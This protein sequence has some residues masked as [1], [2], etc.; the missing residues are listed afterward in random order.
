[1]LSSCTTAG[2]Y[3][4][5]C[6]IRFRLCAKH[7]TWV[8]SASP[9]VPFILDAL[10]VTITESFASNLHSV[11]AS[12]SNPAMVFPVWLSCIALVVAH[13]SPASTHSLCDALLWLRT[14]QWPLMSKRRMSK[15]I[16][17][18]SAEIPAPSLYLLVQLGQ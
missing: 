7:C 10:S 5:F 17:Q 14:I 4:A 1:M 6:E 11:M 8:M 9:A 3:S 15:Q 16:F 18:Q 2:S 12:F 13:V